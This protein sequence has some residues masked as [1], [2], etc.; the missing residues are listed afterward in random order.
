MFS[1]IA[2]VTIISI[3]EVFLVK[4]DDN[5]LNMQAEGLESVEYEHKLLEDAEYS[6]A[7]HLHFLFPIWYKPNRLLKN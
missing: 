3:P 1:L 5:M 6:E 7:V 4:F 2:L